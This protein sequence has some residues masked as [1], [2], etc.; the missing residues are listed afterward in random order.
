MQRWQ[1]DGTKHD[2]QKG[3]NN[4]DKAQQAQKKLLKAGEEKEQ[5][6]MK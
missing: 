4:I 3:I 6:I 5:Q 2:D 1:D